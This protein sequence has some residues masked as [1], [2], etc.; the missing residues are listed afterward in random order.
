MKIPHFEP[1][2]KKNFVVGQVN[3]LIENQRGS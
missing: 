1:I 2:K 3:Q